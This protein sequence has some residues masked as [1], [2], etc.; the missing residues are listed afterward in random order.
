VAV[1]LTLAASV[2][3]L[4]AGPPEVD[5]DVR[6]FG[7][8]IAVLI[9][10]LLAGLGPALLATGLS[11][12]ASAYL[13]LPP[14]FSVQIASEDRM[15][16]LILFIGEG[17]F[18][19]FV[20]D[21]ICTIG[22]ETIDLPRLQRYMAAVLFVLGATGLKLLAWGNFEHNIPFA[23]YYTATAASA[24]V[25]GIG[26]G[27]T[28]VFLSSLCA[29][30]FFIDPTN[31]LAVQ[32]PLAA[33]RVLLFL[34][35]GIVLATLAGRYLPA[36][37]LLSRAREQMRRYGKQWL[38]HSEDA[39]ALKAIS[40]DVI[41]EWDF[42]SFSAVTANEHDTPDVVTP[43]N[44]FRVWL[45]RIHPK[46]RLKVLASLRTAI[47]QGRPEWAYEYRRL[48]PGNGYLHVSD[49]AFIIRD[50]AWNPV[51]VV[52]R[53]TD[54]TDA[55]WASHRFEGNT[56]YRALFERNPQAILLADTGSHIVNAN[57]AACDVL[58]YGRDQLTKLSLDDVFRSSAKGVLL[59]LTP[60]DPSS[61][62]FEDECVKASGEVFRAKIH[63]ATVSGIEES[64]V[65]RI[66]TIEE[67]SESEVDS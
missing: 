51:R 5:A 40:R 19:S 42:P 57:E 18:L 32:S 46:D 22:H 24:W 17:V 65:D 26:P 28:A 58:G 63:A 27:L 14:I 4:I 21:R 60:D 10:S 12:F 23:F 54:V 9:S 53:S 2:S 67:T 44:S 35:E 39:R 34:T 11:A 6:Y 47:E 62:T 49:Q 66:I 15:A 1:V 16:R 30:Y 3:Y 8:A 7:F 36:R 43:E 55:K 33:A 61:I 20:G 64:S 29:R 25:G 59:G 41:W 45:Q 52:G 56:S 48:D 38:K 37:R 31:S 50:H 13:L